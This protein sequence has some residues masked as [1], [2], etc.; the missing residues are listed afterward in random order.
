M[1]SIANLQFFSQVD[2]LVAQYRA[3]VRK[4]IVPTETKKANLNSRLSVLAELKTKLTTLKTTIDDLSKTGS[5]STINAYTVSSSSSPIA[6]GTATASAGE[7]S[8]ALKVTQLAK[9]DT[10]VSNRLTSSATSV[11]TSQGAGTKT[12]GITINGTTTNVSVDLVAGDTN[13][14]I[15]SKI[16]TAINESDAEVSASTVVDTTSTKRLMLV[17]KATGAEQAISLSNVTGTL[18]NDLGLTSGILSG[19][20]QSTSTTAGYSNTNIASLNSIF[21]VDGIDFEKATNNVSDVLTGVTLNFVGVQTETDSPVLLTVSPDKSKIKEK[22]NKF[23]TD[24]NSVLTYL[25][26]KTSTDAIT[27]TRQVLAGNSTF[28]GLKVD[29]RNI[30]SGVVSSVQSGNPKMLTDLGITVARDGTLSLPN[31]TIIDEKLST[32]AAITDLFNSSGGVATRM[33][34]VLQSMLSAGAGQMDV[35]TKTTSTQITNYTDQIARF[36][37]RLDKH[38]EKYRNDFLRLQA[39]MAQVSQQQSVISSITQSYSSY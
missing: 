34:T 9:N 20:T 31:T 11:I 36:D 7:S 25:K 39:V 28:T 18:L 15:L 21:N 14:S 12:I 13:S 24:Y 29:L 32:A 27:N 1:S 22:I 38:V 5:E 2:T 26:L 4:P 6:T 19:R 10:I 35:V 3:S 16:T 17:S 33:K 8:H 30:V 23:I 37:A